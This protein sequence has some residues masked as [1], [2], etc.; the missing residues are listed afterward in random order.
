MYHPRNPG[1]ICVVFDSS[2]QHHGVSLNDVQ[3]TRLDLNNTLIGVLIRFH[4][5][6]MA[7]TVDIQQMFQCFVL[8]KEDGNILR[9]LCFW[10]NDPSEDVDDGLKSFPVVEAAVDLL[11]RTFSQTLT[12]DYTELSQ[13]KE[14]MQAFP[15]QDHANDF[16][17]LDLGSDALPMQR[18]LGFN[19]DLM[20][21]TF[22]F[23]VADEEKPFIRRGIL[24]TVNSI[25]DPL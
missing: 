1:N 23:K 24:A 15:S 22:S 20:S 21:D 9:F 12:C 16:K 13:T 6:A 19:W 4:K 3:L 5:E 8:R 7:F 11:K 17:D 10:D 25:Y 14:V 18:S 2:V